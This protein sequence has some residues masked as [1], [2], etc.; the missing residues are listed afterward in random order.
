MRLCLRMVFLTSLLIL[1]SSSLWSQSLHFQYDDY[2][3]KVYKEYSVESQYVKVTDGTSLA[4]DV[5]LPTQGPSRDAF[6]TIFIYT[7]YGRGFIVPHMGLAKH[8][9][10]TALGFGWGPTYSM[11]D[12]VKSLKMMVAHGYAIV[13]ADMRGTGASYGHQVALMPQL[14]KDGKDLIDWMAQ[15]SWCDGHVGMWGQSY[16]GWAQYM[17]AAQQPAALKCII[18]EVMGFDLYTTGFRPGGILATRW[19]EGF[20]GRLQGGNLNVMEK[21]PIAMPTAPVIDEDGDGKLVDEWPEFERKSMLQGAFVPRYRDKASRDSQYYYQATL[22]HLDN[23]WV[24]TFLDS[25]Y[26][27][28]DV[29]GGEELGN[30]NFYKVG[31]GYNAKKIADTEIPI[32]HIGGWFD[33]FLRGTAMWYATLAPHNPSYLHLGPRFHTSFPKA[34][35]KYLEYDFKDTYGEQMA[36]ERLRFYDHYLKGIDNGFDKDAPVH[37][38]VM[39]EGWREEATWPLEREVMTPFF[40]G[41]SGLTKE[42]QKGSALTYEVDF[43]AY[44][45]YDK[46]SSARMI[47]YRGAPSNVMKRT[48]LDERC[49]VLESEVLTEDVE[50]TG[51]PLAHIWLSANQADA[52]VYVYLSDVDEKGEAY[53]VTDGQLRAGWAKMYDNNVLAQNQLDVKPELPWHGYEQAQWQE[54]ILASGEAVE[55]TF[56]LLPTSWKFKKG[57]KIR[58]SIAG[59]DAATFELNPTICPDGTLGSCAETTY[60]IHTGAAHPSRVELP[61]IPSGAPEQAF[62]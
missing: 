13:I 54:A 30:I 1:I 15:Q 26:Q 57:H 52:D 59:A 19:M 9:G 58:L 51:H 5:I 60:T 43:T 45:G 39:H 50:V 36:K 53:Y 27:F 23:V 55:L 61:I 31:P 22:D 10:S 47:M 14:G 20:S 29:T 21:K 11:V 42:P 32:F 38:Y 48:T 33:G 17:T 56:D 18:P 37:L 6:P 49:L 34:Y 28:I 16:L 4:V 62:R 24:E 35:Q 41:E 7:P 40:L 3:K 2:D 8:I 12:L 25:T 46:D 44:G